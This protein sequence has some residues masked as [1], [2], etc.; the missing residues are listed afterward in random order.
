MTSP[1]SAPKLEFIDWNEPAIELVAKKLLELEKERP[2]DFRRAILVVPTAESGR[3]LRE[4][5]AEKARGQKRAILMPR[6]TLMGHLLRVEEADAAS[7]METTAAWLE[8]L[9][10]IAA[11]LPSEEWAPLFPKAPV[12]DAASWTLDVATSLRQF[13]QTLEQEMLTEEYAKYVQTGYAEGKS[14][15]AAHLKFLEKMD[16]RWPLLKGIFERVDAKLKG[17]PQE[18]ARAELV[19]SPQWK[20]ESRLLIIVCVPE[21]SRQHRKYLQGLH[22]KDGGE[23]QIW[24]NAPKNMESRFDAFGQPLEEYWRTCAIDIPNALGDGE[25]QGVIHRVPGE[26]AMGQLAVMLAARPMPGAKEAPSSNEVCIAACDSSFSPALHMT[27]ARQA[28]ENPWNLNLPEGRSFAMTDAALFPKQLHA[29]L[30]VLER[31]PLYDEESHGI[32]DNCCGLPDEFV[33]LLENRALQ[34]AYRKRAEKKN[35]TEAG[36]R[37]EKGNPL[38]GGF[39]RHLEQVKLL[40][41]PASVG[42]LLEVLNPESPLPCKPDDPHDRIAALA[43]ERKQEYHDYAEYVATIVERCMQ[44]ATM[45]ACLNELAEAFAAISYPDEVQRCVARLACSMRDIADFAGHPQS[46]YAPKL[47]LALLM[48]AVRDTASGK[49][50]EVRKSDSHG[51]I[52]GWRELPFTPA[53]RLVLCGMH[54]SI[55]PEMPADSTFLPDALRCGLGIT[56]SAS[57]EARD[58]FLLTALLQSRP[59]QV[60]FIVACNRPDGA[61]FAPSPLLLRCDEATKEGMD[62]LARR[63]AYLFKEDTFAEADEPYGGMVLLPPHSATG[64]VETIALL[65]KTQEDNPFA[66]KKNGEDE[67]TF[68]PSSLASFLQCPLRFWLKYL[69]KLDAGDTY[70]DDKTDLAPDEYGNATHE[71]L[72]EFAAVRYPDA[73]S[74]RAPDEMKAEIQEMAE[75]YFHDRFGARLSLPLQAQLEHTR[76]NLRKYVDLH[77]ADLQRGWRVMYTEQ[78]L[79]TSLTDPDAAFSMRA[80][81]ID[82]HPDGKWR[83]ID[84]KT[85][86]KTPDAKHLEAIRNGNTVFAKLLPQWTYLADKA[87]KNYRWTEVQLPLYAVAL[88]TFLEDRGESWTMPELAYYNL[89]RSNSDVA[90]SILHSL[91]TLGS[92]A[93]N[94]P[95]FSEDNLAS[96]MACVKDA[97]TKIQRGECLYSA[98][99]LGLDTPRYNDF[100]SLSLD[101]DPRTF[102]DLP[103]LSR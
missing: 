88:K 53:R 2:T 9:H 1:Q 97:V 81:R 5:M 14:L 38:P 16:D 95:A 50:T 39:T 59:G 69:F 17:K 28:S 61:P 48:Q 63:A 30:T 52:L 90:Y 43:K 73:S 72:Q 29:A 11:Q 42:R 75:T 51:D 96:A 71:V 8:V 94:K 18:K 76:N 20:G 80:D 25:Q 86:D 7:V 35:G 47:L 78:E 33:A 74:L 92:N 37:D 36:E 84:Y 77:I 93:R 3:K 44:P 45:P 22:G 66:P 70:D 87:I 100:G 62:E 24:V 46:T 49:L 34:S 31:L 4:Y 10:G 85:S 56:S 65:G 79:K 13:R 102:C 101:G 23:V 6:T 89:P 91:Q 60:H 55:V 26:S 57:R 58:S 103:E 32:R 99:S 41:I 15:P 27:F 21:I 19:N 54:S 67:A 64:G 82:C 40:L 68:S 83:I 98:E 12:G